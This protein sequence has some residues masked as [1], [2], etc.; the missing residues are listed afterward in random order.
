M[1]P[2]R[3]RALMQYAVMR[4]LMQLHYGVYFDYARVHSFM[5]VH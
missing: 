3:M 1:Q 2:I 5:H 4:T